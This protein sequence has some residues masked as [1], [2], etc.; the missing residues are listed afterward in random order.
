MESVGTGYRA[1]LK[2]R[3]KVVR[4]RVRRRPEDAVRDAE[5]LKRLRQNGKLPDA[6]PTFQQAADR[7]RAVSETKRLRPAT[8]DFYEHQLELLTKEF[9]ADTK[10]DRIDAARVQ[11][12]ID[13]RV[14]S[15]VSAGTVKLHMQVLRRV[16]NLAKLTPPTNDPDLI[17]P[18]RRGI[19]PARR[20][21]WKEV[22]E[23]LDSLDDPELGVLAFIAATGI[24]KSEFARMKIED[25]R[26][27]GKDEDLLILIRE[28][29]R[30][31]RVLPLVPGLLPA[32]RTLLS[33]NPYQPDNG[34]PDFVV[35]GD[36]LEQR[37]GWL[38]RVINRARREVRDDRLSLH[39]L[40]HACLTRLAEQGEPIHIVAA[41]AGHKLPGVGVTQTYLHATPASM[42]PAL[43]RLTATYHDGDEQGR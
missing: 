5:D 22:I 9:G 20:L 41:I 2:I 1:V 25:L 6:V 23:I 36:T 4:G 33:L 32:V 14:K 21:T 43:M 12:F 8:I 18:K 27:H 42:R 39:A 16:F 31:S 40:R 11:R 15:G 30:D 13:K 17:L 38:R 29:K 7:V 10:L 28:A 37:K 19:D 3:R 34:T 35:P 24:R 26:V